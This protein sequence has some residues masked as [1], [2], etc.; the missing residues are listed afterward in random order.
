MPGTTV[1]GIAVLMALQA[2]A[3]LF[4]LDPPSDTLANTT[5]GH[6]ATDGR[7]GRP[8]AADTQIPQWDC[9]LELHLHTVGLQ[10]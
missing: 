1:F 9:R 6:G 2:G 3:L 4:S 7:V 8:V 10:A 5:C